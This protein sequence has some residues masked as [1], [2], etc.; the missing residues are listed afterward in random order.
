MPATSGEGAAFRGRRESRFAM[1]R[2]VVDTDIASFIFKRHP[3][4]T[5]RYVDILRGS[6]SIA[7]FMTLAEM[8]RRTVDANWGPRNTLCPKLIWPTSQSFIRTAC[9]APRG[10]SFGTRVRVTDVELVRLSHGLPPRRCHLCAP[11][12]EQRQGLPPFRKAIRRPSR[13]LSSGA[14]TRLIYAA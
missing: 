13:L 7:S 2:L 14:I 6:D 12:D 5:P 10:P 9:C 3:E 8:R 4:F 11:G 1:A